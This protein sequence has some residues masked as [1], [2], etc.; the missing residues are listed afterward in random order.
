MTKEEALSLHEKMWKIVAN[1]ITNGKCRTDCVGE[2]KLIALREMFQNGEIN[3]YPK[4]YCFCCHY[5]SEEK[6]SCKKCP[7][8]WIGGHC[9]KNNSEYI[10]FKVALENCNFETASYLALKISSLPKK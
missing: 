1:N 10:N 5:I 2:Q 3:F 9:C 8:Q 4:N 7:I 6:L